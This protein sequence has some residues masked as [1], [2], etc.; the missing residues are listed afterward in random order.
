LL[1]PT[2]TPPNTCLPRLARQ[3]LA[4]VPCAI[5]FAAPSVA[6]TFDFDDVAQRAQAEARIAYQTPPRVVPPELAALSYDQYRDIRF[7]PEHALLR[8]DGLPFELMFFHLGKFQT[9]PVVVNEL[10]SGSVRHIRFDPSDFDYGKNR[11]SPSTWPDLGYAGF[12]VHYALNTASY[13]DELAVFLGASY[14]RALGGGQRYGLSARGLAIDTAGGQGEE[15][16]RFKEFWIERP[17]VDAKALTVYALLDSQRATGAYRFTLI[18]GAQTVVEVRA[19]LFLRAGVATLGIAPLT[20]MFHH[21]ENSP[22]RDDFRPE[23]HDSDGLMLATADGQGGSEWLWRPLANPSRPLTTSFAV[24]ELEGFGLMQ[25]D[26]A[27]SSYEDVEARYERRPS[28]WVV[29]VGRWGP[30]RVELLQLPTPDETHDNIVA[31]WVPAQPPAPGQPLDLAYRIFW[32]GDEQAR[33]PN[34]WTVQSRFGGGY[35]PL[36]KDE[37]QY[38]VDFAG[39]ALDTLPADAAVDAV[40]T[41]SG[42]ARLVERNAYRNDARGGWRMTLRVARIDPTQPVE[43]RAFLQQGHHALTETWTTVIPVD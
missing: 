29:P 40:I 4:T 18:P 25:R 23:V 10:V 19:R 7:R 8:R 12:R 33:P 31:Y 36:G 13:K 16:P 42:N 21:G 38:V 5:A 20:S 26:R 17:A 39:P 43:L 28:A 6:R 41:P 3:L 34:G 1:A 9:L 22:R 2:P 14:F 11:L 27:F 24:R 30:G 35:A 32:Q 37:F 15:F